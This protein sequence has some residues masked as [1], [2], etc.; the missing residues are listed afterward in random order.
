[1]FFVINSK[2]KRF[3]FVGFFIFSFFS[4][5]FLEYWA[6][7]K[8]LY[9]PSNN[10]YNSVICCHKGKS[11]VYLRIIKIDIKR[12]IKTCLKWP[13]GIRT[14]CSWCNV[15]SFRKYFIFYRLIN[16]IVLE[17]FLLKIC[18]EHTM[19]RSTNLFS[20]RHPKNICL[21]KN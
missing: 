15:F 12:W 7:E 4:T 21:I 17:W 3:A 2:A 19:S 5:T 6:I 16:K 18:K 20:R 10:W 11:S 1:M 8:I 14:S 9:R 13:D